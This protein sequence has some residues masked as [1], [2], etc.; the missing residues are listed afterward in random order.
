MFEYLLGMW[1]HCFRGIFMA[2]YEVLNILES[3][4]F[5]VYIVGGY[6][7]DRFLNR[8]SV[9]ADIITNALPSEVA[10]I[11]CD[12]LIN[13]FEK[14]G[15]VKIKLNGKIIDITTYR[16]ELS[17]SFGKPN[18][19]VFISDI[20]EDLIRRDFTINTLC[21]DKNNNIIDYL[22]II[23]DF[24]LRVIKTTRETTQVL[25][26]DSSRMLRALR[27]MSELGFSLDNKIQ[28][29]ILEN[30][31]DFLKIPYSKRKKEL[32]KLF[33]SGSSYQFFRY[34]K[35]YDLEQYLGI[36]VNDFREVKSSIGVWAQLEMDE[37]YI[38]SKYEK[39]QISSVKYLLN[40]G[41]IEKYDLY[42]YGLDLCLI[43]ANILCIDYE[44]IN[45]LYTNI[46]IKCIMDVDITGN[47][48]C[49]ILNIK[50]SKLVG[51]YL[52]KIEREIVNGNLNNN[53]EEIVKKL[54]EWGE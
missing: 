26:E 15:A 21:M 25:S 42:K 17:Y 33:N 5:E 18:D 2:I 20:K 27:F 16:R 50:P 30:K 45:L 54:K 9:D 24:K 28:T 13:I 22:N 38:F 23:D 47:E 52:S 3:H 44:K 10:L 43:V 11:F 40:K 8:D 51:N 39:E 4:G 14:Y 46:K 37:H 31:K 36:Y 12:N 53:Y 32:D 1:Y 34:I 49:S 41:T 19:I 35:E 48:I 29:Y 7:R 6:V